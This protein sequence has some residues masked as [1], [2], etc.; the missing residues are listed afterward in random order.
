MTTTIRAL[1]ALTLLLAGSTHPTL[2]QGVQTG[3]LTG[4]VQ[5]QALRQYLKP[6]VVFEN[7]IRL[8]DTI[9][10]N[11]EKIIPNQHHLN[12]IL[13]NQSSIIENQ[14]TIMA[15]QDAI[16]GQLKRLLNE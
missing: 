4:T 7:Q 9:I 5:D 12:E 15:N 14:K 8:L 6:G 10:A 11:Q 13:G 16:M 1:F 2:A 3:S